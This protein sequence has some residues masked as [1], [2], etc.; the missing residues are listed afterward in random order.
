MDK[1]VI[2]R[3]VIYEG[4]FVMCEDYDEEYSGMVPQISPI[5]KC[6][7]E[8]LLSHPHITV[9]YKPETPH[10]ELYGCEVYAVVNGYACNGINEGYKARIIPR[11]IHGQN[12]E[13]LGNPVK[14]FADR[15]HT[16][17]ELV[18]NIKVPH[19]TSSISPDGFPKDTAN[20]D[21][22]YLP[23]EEQF[24]VQC[25]YGAFVEIEYDDGSKETDYDYC[26]RW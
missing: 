6:S 13:Y 2:K 9:L 14:D 19:I 17:I 21:F 26:G 3:T 4:L 20:L 5:G 22:E 10:N 25:K 23:I 18:K 1:K 12:M 7:L 8:H 16:L 11:G 15:D 24:I